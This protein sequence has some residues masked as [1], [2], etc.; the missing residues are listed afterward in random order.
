MNFKLR[1]LVAATLAGS[2]LMGFGTSAM[3]DSTDDILNALI[4]KGILTEEEGALLQKGRTGEKQA[5]EDKKKTAVSIKNKDGAMV[6]E[7]GD[8]KNSMALTGRMQFDM[9]SESNN[10]DSSTPELNSDRDT[11][12]MADQF[13]LRRAR[14]GVKGK[15]FE[16]FDY[17]VI[18]NLVGS[19]TNIVDVAYI[20]AGMFKPAQL[21]LGQFKQPFNLE[22]YGTSSNNIDFMERSYVNQLTPAKKTGAM[23]H[24]VPRDGVTYAASIYQQNNFG[25]TDSEN[26]GKGFAGRA[27]LNF[28][29]LA[30]WSDSVFHVGAA[31][32]DSEYGVLPTS[33]SNGNSKPPVCETTQ[34]EDTLEFTTSCENTK[35]ATNGTVLSFRSAGRGLTN[36]YRAQI[37]GDSVQDGP[38]MPSNTAA[39]VK[40]KAYGLEMALAK[41]P[42]KI[43]GEYTDQ[44]FDAS[45]ASNEANFVRADA[46]AYYVEALWM[47][48]GE[49]YSNWYKNGAWGG[50][51][52]TSNFDIATGK[53][54]GAWEIGVRYDAFNVNN[55]AI[56]GTGSRIQGAYQGSD[57][58]GKETTNSVGGGAQT[59]TVG[60]KWQL[61]PNMRVLANYSH[62]KFDDKF[63]A[64][65]T[66]IENIT[67]EDLLMVRSQFSF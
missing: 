11:A 66:T 26:T 52:P 53:G 57:G 21:K 4:A 20:N 5:A 3:A 33:S 24:G 30:G 58:S 65:D 18:G 44:S 1:S 14:I 8:G 12:G 2:M 6:L 38:S 29:E 25:E 59:Y 60:V 31:G 62:T 39:K 64:V 51:K 47:L 7:S 13:E 9:R 46:E 61:T 55:V 54:K 48:T 56:G 41:G 23:L 36:A 16:H 34:D 67:K 10:N 22:E 42:F 37:G 50:I 15:M 40:N 63:R 19:N 28:A 27:T 17:E 49:N 35:A 43:Q 32:F 45:L